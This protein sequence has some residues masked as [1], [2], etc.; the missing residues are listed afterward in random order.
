MSEPKTY[1]E[2]LAGL[3]RLAADRVERGDPY[4]NVRH[5]CTNEYDVWQ[6]SG[7]RSEVQSL[8]ARLH[9]IHFTMRVAEPP[10]ARARCRCGLVGDHEPTCPEVE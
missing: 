1:D 2:E 4:M 8:R 10:P 5:D 7:Y 6:R 3:L 9:S